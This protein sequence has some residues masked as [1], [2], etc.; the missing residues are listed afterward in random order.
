[1]LHPITGVTGGLRDV[2]PSNDPCVSEA[3]LFGV[4]Y[5]DFYHFFLFS[6]FFLPVGESA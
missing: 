3:E 4:F 6:F 1:M 5:R 2:E